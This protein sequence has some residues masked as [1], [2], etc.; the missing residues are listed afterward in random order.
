MFV[1]KGPKELVS[2]LTN[3]VGRMREPPEWPLHGFIPGIVGGQK[4]VEEAYDFLKINNVP[5]AAVWL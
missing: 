5:M 2:T 3:L 1:G 4:F